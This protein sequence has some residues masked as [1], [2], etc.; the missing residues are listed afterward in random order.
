MINENQLSEILSINKYYS[1]KTISNKLMGNKF[2]T[3][4]F[5]STKTLFGSPLKKFINNVYNTFEI[6]QES[7]IISMYYIYNFYE[8]NKNNSQKNE[9]GN[10]KNNDN[11]LKYFFNDINT[12]I[13]TSIVISLKNIYDESLDIRTM[14]YMQNIDFNSFLETERIILNGL[15][16]NTSYQNDDYLQFKNLMVHYMD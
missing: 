16:W 2:I 9:N 8:N 6:P 15:N 7:F 11:V 14:C 13:F 4:K 5:M 3:N 12:F 1:F 10:N